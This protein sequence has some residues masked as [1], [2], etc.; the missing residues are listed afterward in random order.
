[1]LVA[2]Y[3]ANA[4]QFDGNNM[5][6]IKV[7]KILRLPTRDELAK[8][9]QPEAVTE[10]RAQAADWNAYRQ[11]LA[12]AAS[13]SSQSQAARQVVT[14]KIT[15][16]VADKAPVAKES[17]REVLKLSNGEVPGDKVGAGATGKAVTEQ[18]MKNA[19]QEDAITKAKAAREEQ[20]RVA[21]LEKN[22]KDM[23]RLAELK[24]A[25]VVPQPSLVDR[26]L[27]EPAYLAGIAAAVLGLGGLG[28]MLSGGRQ[29]RA[30]GDA[31]AMTDH[32]A[33]PSTET[34]DKDVSQQA[35]AKERKLEPDNP[36]YGGAGTM[37]HA[38][39]APAVQPVL[40]Q[41]ENEEVKP[42]LDFTAEKSAPAAQAAE[43]LLAGISLHLDG[44]AL[45]SESNQE[46]RDERWHEVATKLDLAKAYREMGDAAGAREV[47][48]EALREGD[49][50]QR[51]AAQAQLD[52]LV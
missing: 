12:S 8:V 17:A 33:A 26:V 37:E 19:A 7:G 28:L 10:I 43:D 2:L 46:S 34:G 15:S 44:A 3:R 52:Q 48:G 51:A 39:S 49:A 22:I 27:G 45:P 38:D 41:A 20:G 42:K 16:S 5:N 14:G 9:T 35:A 36:P 31:G 18:E 25:V 40:A 13:A 29:A 11:K 50:G 24:S 21:L 47:L 32:V 6:R 1:M 4:D 30:S 23:Q